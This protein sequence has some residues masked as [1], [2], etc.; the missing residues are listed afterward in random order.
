MLINVAEIR[1][2]KGDEHTSLGK[3]TTAHHWII[4]F[5]SSFV[6]LYRLLH[7]LVGNKLLLW[8]S[9]EDE[10]VQN[11]NEDELDYLR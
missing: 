3:S 2:H 8:G 1:G 11:S 10:E 7:F 9:L 6:L 4:I 5:L